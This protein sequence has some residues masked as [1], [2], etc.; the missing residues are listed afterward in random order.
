[1]PRVLRMRHGVLM[2]VTNYAQPTCNRAIVYRCGPIEPARQDISL[3]FMSMCTHARVESRHMCP[4][5]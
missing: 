1:M 3:A 5:L 2:L 4:T